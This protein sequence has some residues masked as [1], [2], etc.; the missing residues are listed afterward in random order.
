FLGEIE[1]LCIF[2]SEIPVHNHLF[3][4]ALS[5]V[6]YL[7]LKLLHQAEMSQIVQAY[8][9]KGRGTIIFECHDFLYCMR[10][11]IALLFVYRYLL[12]P[13]LKCMYCYCFECIMYCYCFECITILYPIIFCTLG[14]APPLSIT[15]MGGCD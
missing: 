1:Y 15:A 2:H 6:R 7:D 13:A 8:C 3:D 12:L 11:L 9:I 10:A 5:S 4:T 14:T